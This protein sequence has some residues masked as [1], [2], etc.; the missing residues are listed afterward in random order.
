MG[1][2]PR[3]YPPSPIPRHNRVAPCENTLGREGTE[4]E[5]QLPESGRRPLQACEGCARQVIGE[6]RNALPS[7]LNAVKRT[8]I[9][10]GARR[11]L[12]SAFGTV[13]DERQCATAAISKARNVMS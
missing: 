6:L 7:P 9:I 4:K 8:N 1:I 12:E 11:L 3:A 13:N 2:S 5:V 10:E